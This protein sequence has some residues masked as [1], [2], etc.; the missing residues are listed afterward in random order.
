[1]RGIIIFITVSYIYTGK[2][3]DEATFPE[4]SLQLQ[5]PTQSV[6][7]LASPIEKGN[8]NT[9]ADNW[10]SSVELVKELQQKGLTYVGTTSKNKRKIPKEFQPSKERQ[11][12]S[13]LY[14]F[15]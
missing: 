4:S 10:F 14:G 7:R 6:I 12:G 13:T 8:R 15:S 5:K 1:M 11:I 3:S 2:N 9:T